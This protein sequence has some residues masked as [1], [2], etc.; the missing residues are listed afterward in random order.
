MLFL[1]LVFKGD[2]K[3]KKEVIVIIFY[4]IILVSN[5]CLNL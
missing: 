4:Q 5:F 2:F 3:T 1:L